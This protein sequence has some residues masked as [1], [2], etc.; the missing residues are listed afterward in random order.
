MFFPERK[1]QGTLAHWAPE[2]RARPEP[3]VQGFSASFPSEEDACL[4]AR[5]TEFLRGSQQPLDAKRPD[6]AGPD[7]GRSPCAVRLQ[8]AGP[9]QCLTPRGEAQRSIEAG[10]RRAVTGLDEHASKLAGEDATE[11]EIMRKLVFG[12]PPHVRRLRSCLGNATHDVADAEQLAAGEDTR[13]MS[14]PRSVPRRGKRAHLHPV[15]A[16]LL[17]FLD[18]VFGRSEVHV[19]P[20]TG[21]R[22]AVATGNLPHHQQA[23]VCVEDRAAH[24]DLRRRVALLRREQRLD[25][26]NASDVCAA[27]ILDAS[28]RS[29]SQCSRSHPLGSKANPVRTIAWSSRVQVS[30]SGSALEA[31]LLAGCRSV[32]RG[33]LP[34]R[35]ALSLR[36]RYT[37]IGKS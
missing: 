16:F 24:V 32:T 29:V 6:G 7:S 15:T 4:P 14:L 18:D 13:W 31:L 22:P 1:N 36:V 25:P 17:R 34:P 8:G 27:M 21:H 37:Q 2:L 26:M 3:R 12:K 9:E 19:C 23:A 28:A 33:T 11:R 30:Q 5:S 20:T 10:G 35:A